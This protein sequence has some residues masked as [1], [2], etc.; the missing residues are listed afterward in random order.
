MRWLRHRLL[1]IAFEINVDC[2]EQLGA[3]HIDDGVEGHLLL[4]IQLLLIVVRDHG[5]EQF[6]VVRLHLFA[7][8]VVVLELHLELNYSPAEA[9]KVVDA[10]PLTRKRL[11]RLI[12]I[13]V[14]HRFL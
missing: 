6:R 2:V 8:E 9:S 12:V 10:T 3:E 13:D 11:A 14:I 7:F 4:D 1:P 5:R